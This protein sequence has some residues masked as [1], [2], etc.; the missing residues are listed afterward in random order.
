MKKK[1]P[2]AYLEWVNQEKGQQGLAGIPARGILIGAVLALL[3]NGLDAYA[4]TII[5]GSYLTLNFSTPAALFF[6]FFLVPAS[7]LV[8]CPNRLR[9]S[10]A[11]TQSELI[12]IYIMRIN[13]REVVGR[14]PA[15]F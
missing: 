8:Y 7:G 6:F 9:R 2:P 5:R 1:I 15:A 11:L 13:E 10:L 4:T 14:S 12:T 3:L